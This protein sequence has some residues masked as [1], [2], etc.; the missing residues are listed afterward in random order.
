MRGSA[1]E[2]GRIGL[3]ECLEPRNS[4]SYRVFYMISMV[5]GWKGVTTIPENSVQSKI[6]THGVVTGRR[7]IK[8]A[9][10]PG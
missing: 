3:E 4:H 9:K 8:V 10:L 2:A 7:Q 1:Q 6:S 5:L